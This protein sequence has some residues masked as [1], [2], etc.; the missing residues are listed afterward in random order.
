MSTPSSAPASRPLR[1]PGLFVYLAGLGTSAFALWIVHLLND[2]GTN[3]MGWYVNGILPAGALLVGLLSGVGYAV[4]SR[5]LNVKLSRA[6]VFGMITTAIVDYAAAQYL[7]W[8]HLMEK[9]HADPAQYTFIDWF[10]DSCEQMA[11][12]SS[13]SGSDEPGSALG[14]WGYFFKFLELAG[15]ALGAMLP[16]LGVFGMPYCKGC[17]YYLKSHRKGYLSSEEQWA[18]TKKLSSKERGP[19]LEACI[20]KL[21]DRTQ[22]V[23]AEMAETSLAACERAVEALDAAAA[24]GSSANVLFHLKKCPSCEAHFIELT[25]TNYKVDKQVGS[26]SLLK[27]DKTAAPEPVQPAAA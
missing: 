12:T 23:V 16:S 5:V 18:D 20:Q 6:F 8:Q 9:F 25:L 10:R 4:A 2:S 26:T 22:P 24:K 13:R 21:V 1:Q 3:V 15:Y 11:F 17:Q 27:L 14:V 7:T 19:A